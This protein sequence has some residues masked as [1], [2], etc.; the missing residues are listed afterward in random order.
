MSYSI[1]MQLIC[2][3][4]WQLRTQQLAIMGTVSTLKYKLCVFAGSC[5]WVR[6]CVCARASG[7]ERASQTSIHQKCV[8]CGQVKYT[9]NKQSLWVTTKDSAPGGRR[10]EK[11]GLPYD[12]EL[13]DHMVLH[14][15]VVEVSV[16][17]S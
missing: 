7:S 16:L 13:F 6:V 15:V 4:C 8:V 3:V 1:S 12:P 9:T 11:V 5:V 14:G 2:A 10:T 17:S